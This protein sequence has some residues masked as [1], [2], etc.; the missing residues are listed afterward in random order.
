M[1]GDFK[2][3]YAFESPAYRKIF[4]LDKFRSHFGRDV[5]WLDVR[6]NEVKPDGVDVAAVRLTMTYRVMM[7]DSTPHTGMADVEERWL[8]KEGVWWHVMKLK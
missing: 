2:A 5:E 7:P 3:A 1:K 8:K 4:P 6:V